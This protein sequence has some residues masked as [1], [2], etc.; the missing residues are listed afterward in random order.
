[1]KPWSSSPTLVGKCPVSWRVSY[2]R[3]ALCG[4]EPLVL[5]ASMHSRLSE[6]REFPSSALASVVPYQPALEL[7]LGWQRRTP[8]IHLHFWLMTATEMKLCVSLNLLTS[9]CSSQILSTLTS[10]TVSEALKKNPMF[11]FSLW[12]FQG[13]IQKIRCHWTQIHCFFKEVGQFLII[14]A[15]LD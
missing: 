10:G 12:I 7:R 2:V 4:V 5:R 15:T 9:T 3:W 6:L 1:M 14:A 13:G 11:Y 8:S